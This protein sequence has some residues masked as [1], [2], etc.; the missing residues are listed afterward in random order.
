VVSLAPP[1]DPM[2]D[3]LSLCEE[4]NGRR[5]WSGDLGPVECW[6]CYGS[7]ME[8]GDRA[9]R[10]VR[11]R[12]NGLAALLSLLGPAGMDHRAGGDVICPLCGEA[13]REHATCSREPWIALL[14]DGR[15]VKL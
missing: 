5:R 7:G 1:D 8:G 9:A 6:R 10:W 11:R 4:C 2:G 3:P 13:Y 12:I 15:R 14:C